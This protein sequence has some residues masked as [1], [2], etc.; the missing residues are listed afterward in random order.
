M[1]KICNVFC[2]IYFSSSP[3]LN[4]IAHVAII[5]YA[6][7]QC[8]NHSCLFFADCLFKICPLSRYSAQKQFWKSVRQSASSV[9]SAALLNKLSVCILLLVSCWS[10]YVIQ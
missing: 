4:D 10:T 8:L 1:K 9:S 3:Y 6:A 7:V 2:V 5:C